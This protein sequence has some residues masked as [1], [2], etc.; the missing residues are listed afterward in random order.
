MIMSRALPLS[1]SNAATG[2][3][4]L[5]A[6]VLAGAD[7]LARL[8]REE[9]ASTPF[10]SSGW[11]GAFLEAHGSMAV[12]RLIE[13]ADGHGNMLLLPV[14]LV[15]YARMTV[16]S[17]VGG[18]HA[19]YFFPGLI[20]DLSVWSA[21]SLRAALREAGQAAGIDAFLLADC[22][23]IWGGRA[24]PLSRLPHQASPSDGAMLTIDTAG[25]AVLDRLFDREHRKKQRYKRRK[26]GETGI[27]SSGWA[28][29]DR[30]VEVVLAAFREWKA[31]QFAS[32]GVADPFA[33]S[34]IQAFLYKMYCSANPTAR[35]FV[36][37]LDDRP[38]AVVGTTQAG[39]H[40]SGMFTAYDPDP[41]IARF[42]PGD[43]LMADLVQT[44]S[45]ED[46][47]SFD[48]GIGEARYKSHFCPERMAMVDIAVTVSHPGRLAALTWRAMR[49]AKRIIKQ[50]PTA[51]DLAKGL[52]R[53]LSI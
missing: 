20:G 52:R 43:V 19:S 24:N 13:I 22:P 28:P 26:L 50:N 8:G 48:L 14:Q 34:E 12:F 38:I 44:L 37:Q 15:P 16:A 17:K 46:V 32:L 35:L 53:R 49:W 10:Q 40:V 45:T 1:R 18:A 21:L 31:K 51:Y 42:S 41:G 3:D 9:A 33:T 11:L 25:E 36:L 30:S 2:D 29:C 47:G 23:R 7:A 5:R 4:R 6:T 39:R 27:V